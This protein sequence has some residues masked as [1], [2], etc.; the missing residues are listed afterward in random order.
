MSVNHDQVIKEIV[1]HLNLNKYDVYT[2]PGQEHNAGIDENYPDV[3][4][5][6]KGGNTVK[7]IM[8]VET[9][10]SVNTEESKSQWKKYFDEINATLY[11]VVPVTSLNRAKELCQRIGINARFVL[12]SEKAGRIFFDF[13]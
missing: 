6:V 5:T 13:Q 8:E 4:L 10:D 3:I 2:N 12:Y 11:L 9:E 7:F 1:N